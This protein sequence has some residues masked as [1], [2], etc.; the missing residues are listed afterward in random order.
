MYQDLIHASVAE[1]LII[2]V[3]DRGIPGSMPGDKI[4][5]L[6][7]HP[8]LD[9]LDRDSESR[10]SISCGVLSSPPTARWSSPSRFFHRIPLDG[11]SSMVP[12]LLALSHLVGYPGY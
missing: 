2:P 10:W 3:L 11:R 7:L 8:N 4:F 9:P 1:R 6:R 5:R 12:A